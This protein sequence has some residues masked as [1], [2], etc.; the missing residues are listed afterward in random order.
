IL[1]NY[2]RIVGELEESEKHLKASIDIY[3]RLGQLQGVFTNKLRLAHTYQWWTNYEVSN[4]MFG[5]LLELAETDPDYSH[6][7]DFIYQHCGKNQFDQKHFHEALDYF[8][9]SLALRLEKGDEELI[10]ITKADIE[11]CE[12]RLD[13]PEKFAK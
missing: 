9:K 4:D 1:G 11:A 10:S 6:F 8:D 3:N 13:H 7:L 5:E 12:Y 2:L